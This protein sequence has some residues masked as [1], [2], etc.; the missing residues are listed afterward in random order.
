[1]NDRRVPATAST[2]TV[3][4]SAQQYHAWHTTGAT[5]STSAR[6]RGCSSRSGRRRTHGY[7]LDAILNIYNFAEDP[8]LREK[9]GMILDLDFADYA[10]QELN[11]IW[12]GA[13]SRSFPA[14]SYERRRRHHDQLRRPRCSG[15]ASAMRQP[16]AHA[17]DQWLHARHRSCRRSRPI[18]RDGAASPTSPAGPVTAT[19]AATSTTTGT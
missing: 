18:R 10:Q 12:G 4:P 2:P 3:Q 16:R 8:V 15:P 14:N 1:M 19:T 5:T 17:R 6:S 9:A 13:K 11:D 7:L